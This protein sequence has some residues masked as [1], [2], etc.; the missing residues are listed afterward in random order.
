MPKQISAKRP[1]RPA[2]EALRTEFFPAEAAR[3]LGLGRID[4]RQLRRI[5]DL[6]APPE[7]R[8]VFQRGRRRGWARFSFRDLLA[9]KLAI[10][11]ARRPRPNARRARLR[12]QDVEAAA[13]ALAR[14]SKL[15]DPL[16]D[17]TWGVF[18]STVIAEVDGVTIDPRTRQTLLTEVVRG[19]A[20]YMRDEERAPRAL[21]ADLRA[22]LSA[23]VDRIRLPHRERVAR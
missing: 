4:Y 10:F 13:T 6:V 20:E 2:Q 19:A 12:L 14:H 16:L 9:A 22:R 3:I 7:R 18:G 1:K 11:L 8:G 17:A 23:E 15:T 5:F 21:V